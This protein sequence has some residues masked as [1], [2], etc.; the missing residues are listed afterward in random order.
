MIPVIATL[1][2]KQMH[3]SQL[4]VPAL[5]ISEL[6][7]PALSTSQL[8]VPVLCPTWLL[9]TLVNPSVRLGLVNL[10]ELNVRIRV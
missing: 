4:A 8:A 10:M 9:D 3:T 7:V 5:C 2:S 6:A 1:P